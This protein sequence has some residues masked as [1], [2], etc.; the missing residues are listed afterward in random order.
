MPASHLR[1]Y[2]LAEQVKGPFISLIP[3]KQAPHELVPLDRF[4]TLLIG[5]LLLQ[6]QLDGALNRALRHQPF[7]CELALYSFFGSF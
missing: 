3:L 4:D 7:F 6:I 1:F 5:S 2:D